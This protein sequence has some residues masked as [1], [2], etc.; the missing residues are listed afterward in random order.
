MLSQFEFHRETV[1]FL[2][3]AIPL[4]FRNTK[5]TGQKFTLKFTKCHFQ[6]SEYFPTKH[7]KMTK[8][9]CFQE[10]FPIF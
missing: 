1:G 9:Y 5:N 2:D 6:Q 7:D 3:T 4:T 8:I 10:Y